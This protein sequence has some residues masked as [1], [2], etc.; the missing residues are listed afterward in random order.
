[1]K[2]IIDIIEDMRT[3]IGNDLSFSVSAMGLKEQENGEYLPVWQSDI[4]HMKLDEEEKK[5]FLFLGKDGAIDTKELMQRL[6]VLSNEM[7]MYEVCV[8]YS[9]EAQR[10]DSALI[11]FGESV[12]D[13][14]YLLFIPD[15]R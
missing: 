11:G 5:L 8:S 14:K 6:N 9:Q 12:E 1:M 10:I 2:L 3:A 13:K 15:I 7:M 4:T